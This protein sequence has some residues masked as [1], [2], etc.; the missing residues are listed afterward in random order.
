[1]A[2]DNDVSNKGGTRIPLVAWG[3]GGVLL[4]VAIFLVVRGDGRPASPVADARMKR[5]GTVELIDEPGA[6]QQSTSPQLRVVG[7]I[8]APIP[9]RPGDVVHLEIL[10]LPA[11]GDVSLDLDLVVPSE[12][13]DA[14]PVQVFRGTPFTLALELETEALEGDRNRARVKIPASFFADPGRYI[15]MVETT[16]KASLPFRRY[17]IEV[18]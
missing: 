13:A 6:E 8:D 7:E 17:A 15:I 3:A 16:E 9:L 2:S 11:G 14:R 10:Q 5:P 1:M 18:H 4:L 12:S